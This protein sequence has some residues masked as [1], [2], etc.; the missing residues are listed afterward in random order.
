MRIK[1]KKVWFRLEAFCPLAKTWIVL[2][3]TPLNIAIQSSTI[4]QPATE[5]NQ[6]VIKGIIRHTFYQR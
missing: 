1:Y 5:D 2:Q 4:F 3:D 6:P